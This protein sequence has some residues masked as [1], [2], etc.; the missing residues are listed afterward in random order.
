LAVVQ[1][2]EIAHR[3]QRRRVLRALCLLVP[4]QRPHV[5]ILD[6]FR[7]FPI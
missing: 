5:Q 4:A 1:I 3:V 7:L 6:F 2:A